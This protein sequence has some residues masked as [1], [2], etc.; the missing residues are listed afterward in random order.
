MRCPMSEYHAEKWTKVWNGSK[1]HD[2][3]AVLDSAGNPV[4][5]GTETT[6]REYIDE[7]KQE[8]SHE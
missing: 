4:A 8:V 7:L 3:W 6:M 5:F 1:T 2:V